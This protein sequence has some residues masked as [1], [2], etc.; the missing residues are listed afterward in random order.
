[1]LLEITVAIIFAKIFSTLFE[2]IKQPGVLGEIIAGVILGPCCIGLLSGSS[3]TFMNTSLFQ[4]KL[5]LTSPEFKEIAFIGVVFLLFIVGLETNLSDLKKTRKAGLGVGIFGIIIP[6]IF[7]CI[8]G[9][10][11][12]LTLIQ[13][14]AIGTI[15]LATSTTIAIRILSDMD[16]LSSRVGLTLRTA[17]VVND[18]LAMVFFALVFGVGNSFVL[19]LQISLFFLLTI[20]IGFLLVRYSLKRETKRHTPI[21][22]LTSGLGI[23]FLFAAF[24]ENMGL[25][26]IIGAFIAGIFIKKTPQA[27]VLAEYIKTIGYAFFVPLFF[28]W[29]GASFD[30][31]S[32]FQSNQISSLLIF[33]AAFIIFAM[34]G[35]FL[36]SFIGARVSGLKS[37]ESISIGIGM[38]PVM[39]VALIIVSTGIDRKIF[40]DPGGILA[41]QIRTATLFL[42]FTSCFLTPLLL[43][44]SMGSPL[45]KKIGKTKTKLSSYHHP[46]CSEC[47]TALRLDPAT[48]KW[49][50]DTCRGYM[51]LHKKTPSYALN[52]R[53]KT[54]KYIKYVIGA[55]TILLCGYVIQGSATMSF[56]E[57]ISALIGIFLG[58]TLAF[59]TIRFLFSNQKTVN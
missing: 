16:L 36:G 46:H 13:S 48:N 18:V 24:A 12:H 6:F 38:M 33:C 35:N 20:I 10:L 52:G 41:N 30:F 7:G 44:R 32:L 51:E 4:F 1:M 14:M 17:L 26:A 58:T 3:F 19:L 57:K 43:K 55:G 8:I 50:C 28:V 23:C 5:D 2:K 40:G 53:G 47:F 37:K 39:G 9:Q 11:F 31:L 29:V 27:G 21:I 56:F 45:L 54:D 15:F 22:V 34:L 49:Y 59:L 25:T 42:I